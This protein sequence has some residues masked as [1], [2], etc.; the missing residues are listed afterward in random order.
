M[1]EKLIE[2]TKK[3]MTLKEAYKLDKEIIKFL[4]DNSIPSNE[5]VKL[6]A[7]GLLEP[8]AIASDGYKKK[9]K[10]EHYKKSTQK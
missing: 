3:R 8:V 9:H 5:K 4:N 6:R 10:L 1:V 7:E 2:R